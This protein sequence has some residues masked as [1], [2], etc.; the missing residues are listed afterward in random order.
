MKDHYVTDP[1]KIKE[2]LGQYPM[3][4]ALL[5]NLI[6]ELEVAYKQGTGVICDADEIMLAMANGTKQ[7]IDMPLAPSRGGEKLTD[8]I[9]STTKILDAEY[10]E[11]LKSLHNDIFIFDTTVKKIN[12]AVNGLPPKQKRILQLRYWQ[13]KTWRQ[14][15]DNER[16]TVNRT[17]EIHRLGIEQICKVLQIDNDTYDYVMGKVR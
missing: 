16:I 17:K 7:L 5:T 3:L 11:L 6:I 2:L 4:E 12:A 9:V 15:S 13:G 14:T 8:I 1:I 10:R